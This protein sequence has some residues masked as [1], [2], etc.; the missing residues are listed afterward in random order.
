MEDAS[1]IRGQVEHCRA[2]LER[3]SADAGESRGEVLSSTKLSDLLDRALAA[4][5]GSDQVHLS[6]AADTGAQQ[7]TI[8]PR[9]FAQAIGSVLNNAVEASDPGDRVDLS[10]EIHDGVLRLTVK[11]QGGGMSPEVLARAGE[12]FFTTKETGRGMGLGVFL[13][14]SLLERMAGTLRIDSQLDV[15][16]EVILEVP[17]GPPES[18]PSLGGR[19][20]R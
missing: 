20:A 2:V 9:A 19:A 1:L 16:T 5:P 12:P 6:L 7:L 11:D 14:R 3:L 13:A 8:L 15:G 18:Q 4:T 10:A 17:C